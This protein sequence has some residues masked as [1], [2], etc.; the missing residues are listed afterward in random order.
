MGSTLG[1]LPTQMINTYM[2]STVRSM[3]EVLADRADGYI[4][5]TIQVVI[6]IFL[7]FY[8]V[9]KARQELNKLSASKDVEAGETNR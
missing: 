6:S 8:L 2:G 3:Q 4:M 9:R 5:L 1:L 7:S